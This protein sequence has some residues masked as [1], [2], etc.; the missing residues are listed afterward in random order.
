MK[1]RTRWV[2]L[3]LAA[4][5]TSLGALYFYLDQRISEKAQALLMQI[6]RMEGE[7]LP[8]LSPTV[9]ANLQWLEGLSALPLV[10]KRAGDVAA[11]RSLMAYGQLHMFCDR[12]LRCEDAERSEG[13]RRLDCALRDEATAVALYGSWRPFVRTLLEP[14]AEGVMV[15]TL[16]KAAVG[17]GHSLESLRAYQAACEAQ[18]KK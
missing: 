12:V 7:R 14:Q 16:R 17:L 9:L 15:E 2:A 10:G 3:I 4:L 6:R 5:V 13:L 1:L 18:L 8:S 11:D